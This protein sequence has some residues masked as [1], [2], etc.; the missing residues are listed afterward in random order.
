MNIHSNVSKLALGKN[1]FPENDWHEILNQV[2]AKS[3]AKEKLPE[4]FSTSGIYYPKRISVEQSSSEK[5]A[6]YKAGL[7]SGNLLVDL[8]GGMGVDDYYFSKSVKSVVHCEIDCGLSEITVNNFRALSA[9]NINCICGDSFEILKE[10]DHADWIYVDPS[11]RSETK[12]KVF[13][14]K[15]CLP[16]VPGNLKFYFSKTERILIKTSPIL[17]IAAGISELEN[18]KAIHIVAVK[19]EVKEL[20]WELWKG[21]SGSI[22]MKTININSDESE[23][24]FD[25]TLNDQHTANYAFPLQ[26]LYE[27]NAAIMKSGGF[28]EVG[29]V[30]P[31]F[32]LHKHSHLY[33]S[34]RIILFPGRVFR[35][36][37]VVSYN[38][39][40]LKILSGMGKANITVRNFPETVEQLRK[41]LRISD[42]GDRF[43]FFTTDK[44]DNKIALIC[45][46]IT[47]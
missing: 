35:I 28:E 39:A 2:S 34:D 26:Y 32:K 17:D 46:K 36:D 4:W 5:T 30:F 38:K 40:G 42:G 10:Y 24:T 1:P 43:C 9:S 7:V 37:E 21:Y 8:T 3:K 12:G 41:K 16:D 15:D 22:Q 25:F 20:L 23:D 44:D 18:I 33:T 45:T 47:T 13:M 31:I 11:R 19:N 14:L 6:K 29:A 27:P